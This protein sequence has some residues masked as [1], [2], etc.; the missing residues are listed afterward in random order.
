[1]SVGAIEVDDLD[2]LVA[3]IGILLGILEQAQP[4]DLYTLNTGWFTH[5]AYYLSQVPTK[6]AG[7]LLDVLGQLLDAAAGSAVGTPHQ[8][9]GRTWYPIAVPDSSGQAEASPFYLVAPTA[10]TSGSGTN[11]GDAPVLGVGFRHDFDAG[12]GA[13]VTAYGYLPL[14]SLA[15]SGVSFVLEQAGGGG[16]PPQ[17]GIELTGIEF[18]SG[19]VSF[20]GLQVAADISFSEA[21]AVTVVFLNLALPGR[22]PA[23]T[24]LQDLIVLGPAE[25]LASA[26]SLVFGQ[27]ARLLPDADRQAAENVFGDLLE[28]LG[29][30]PGLPS[31][32]WTALAAALVKDGKP[33]AGALVGGWLATLGGTPATMRQWLNALACLFNGTTTAVDGSDIAG[34]VPGAGTQADPFRVTV[35][36]GEGLELDLLVGLGQVNGVVHIYP[37]VRAAGAPL[38]LPDGLAAAATIGLSAQVADLQVSPTSLT[39]A[40]AQSLDA[41]VTLGATTAG[42]A[43]FGFE[44]TDVEPNGALSLGSVSGG[45]SYSGGTL[46]PSFALLDVSTPI[47]SWPVI[48]LANYGQSVAALEKAAGGV[49]QS[50]IETFLGAVGSEEPTGAAAAICAVLGVLAPAADA[51]NWPVSQLLFSD[52]DALVANPLTAVGAYWE[53]VIEA[54]DLPS[55][56]APVTVLLSSLATVLGA[57]DSSLSGSG[58]ALNPWLATLATVDDTVSVILSAWLEGSASAGYDLHLGLRFGVPFTLQGGQVALALDAG[59]IA[60]SLP[61]AG[62]GSY[63]ASWFELAGVSAALSGSALT[64]PAVGGVSLTA[65]AVVV[66]GGYGRQGLYG[67]V[68]ATG[69]QLTAGTVETPLGDIDVTVTEAGW[70]SGQLELLMGAVLQLAGLWLLEN[71][72]RPGVA[73]ATVLGLLPDIAAVYA[74]AGSANA[75]CPLPAGFTLPADWPAVTISDGTTFLG[76]P[77]QPFAAQLQALLGTHAR[78]Q[79]AIGLCAWALTGTVTI[80]QQA[81]TR[82]APMTVTLPGPLGLDVLVWSEGEANL[83]TRAGLGVSWTTTAT[84]ADT[85][86][87]ATTLRCDIATLPLAAPAPTPAGPVPQL[88]ASV[89]LAGLD[90]AP[91]SSDS[92]SGLTIG[93]ALV[94]VAWQRDGLTPLL[95]FDGVV[96]GQSASAAYTIADLLGRGAAGGSSNPSASTE[97]QVVA[98]LTGTVMQMLADDVPEIGIPDPPTDR[99]LAILGIL[100][101]VGLAAPS[102]GYYAIDPTS[103]LAFLADPAG[104]LA[105]GLAATL[106]D[107]DGAGRLGRAVGALAGATPPPLSADLAPIWA[108]L[109]SLGLATGT[110]GGPVPKPEAWTAVLQNPAGYLTGAAGAVF[111]DPAALIGELGT[112]VPAGAAQPVQLGGGVTLAVDKAT[113]VTLTVPAVKPGSWLE[114]GGSFILDLKAMSLTTG[115]TLAVPP[116]ALA[117]AASVSVNGSVESSW[118][119]DV[120]DATPS[121]VPAAFDPIPILGADAG[122]L[123]VALQVAVP[124]FAL[125]AVAGELIER[126]LLADSALARAAFTAV[127]LVDPADPARVRGLVR[128]ARAPLAWLQLALGVT[129]DGTLNLDVV[130]TRLAAIG[131]AAGGTGPGGV[132]LAASG[133]TGLTVGGLPYESSVSLT[134]SSAGGVACAVEVS[135]DVSPCTLTLSPSLG[136]LPASGLTLGGSVAGAVALSATTVTLDGGYAAG[137]WSLTL[138]AASGSPAKTTFT[139][140]LVPF[141]GVNAAFAASANLLL[142]YVVDEALTYYNATK[143][144]LPASVQTAVDG[145]V[146][147]A[148]TLGVTDGTSL[149]TLVQTIEK[150]PVQWLDANL[151]NFVGAAGAVLVTT[152]Q[153]PGVSVAGNLITYTRS[154]LPAG[155]PLTVSFGE[156]TDLTPNLLGAWLHAE[157]TFTPFVT[158]IDCGVGVQVP[159]PLSGDPVIDGSLQLVQCVDPTVLKP[160]APLLGSPAVVATVAGQ[161]VGGTSSFT[162]QGWPV[163]VVDVTDPHAGDA[164]VIALAPTPGLAYGDAPGTLLSTGYGTWLESFAYGFGYPILGGLVLSS[165]EVTTWLDATVGSSGVKVGA[166]LQALGLLAGSSGAW[167]PAD[168]R[169][170]FRTVRTGGGDYASFATAKLL[171]VLELLAGAPLITITVDGDS[172]SVGIAKT[173]D[174]DGGNV[175]GVELGLPEVTLATSAGGPQVVFQPGSWPAGENGTTNWIS[176]SNSDVTASQ[177]GIAI[178]LVHAPSTGSPTLSPGLIIVSAGLDL[179]GAPGKPLVDLPEFQLAGVETRVYVSMI[180]DLSNGG[181]LTTSFGAAAACTGLALSLAPSALAPSAGQSNPVAQ[182]LLSSGGGGSDSAPAKSAAPALTALAA[183]VEGG[184]LV[185]LLS[186]PANP[187]TFTDQTVWIPVQRALGPL[188]CQ[189]VGV[190]PPAQSG[191]QTLGIDFDGSVSLAGL[192][193]DLDDLSIGIPLTSPVDFDSYTLGLDGMSVALSGGPVTIAGGLVETADTP[194]GYEGMILVQAADLGLSAIGAYSVFDQ[195]PSFFVFGMLRAPLG[196]PPF[197]FVTGIAAGFGYNR[198]LAL[199]SITADNVDTFPLMEAMAGSNALKNPTDQTGLAATLDALGTAV[200]PSPGEYWLAAGVSFTSFDLLQS[201][202]LIAVSFGNDFRVDLL[203]VSQLVV[204]TAGGEI[205]P[206]VSAELDLDAS[207]RPSAGVL[208]VTATL[209]P[210]SHV[211]DPAVHLTGGFALDVWFSGDEEGQFVVTLGG[212]H[213][214]W[215]PPSF[216]PQEPRLGINWSWGNVQLTGDA[217]FALTPT[218]VMAGGDLDLTY[219]AGKLQAWLTVQADFLITWHPFAFEVGFEVSVGASYRVDA[220]LVHHTFTVELGA[221]VMMHGMPMGGTAHVHWYVI[222]FTISFGDDAVADTLKTWADFDNQL[223]PQPAPSSSAT[224]LVADTTPQATAIVLRAQAL[225]GVLSVPANED[226]PWLIT[227]GFTILVES[228][229]PV[230]EACLDKPTNPP[231][232]TAPASAPLGVPPLG[233]T[234]ASGTPCLASVLT[235]SFAPSGGGTTAE[236]I[237]CSPVVR[238]VPEA[239]WSPSPIDTTTPAANTIPKVV[240][241]FQ[242]SADI[243]QI[244]PRG[245]FA[246]SDLQPPEPGKSADWPSDSAATQ[247]TTTPNPV[248]TIMTTLSDSTTSAWRGEVLGALTPLNAAL[249]T[250]GTLPVLGAFADQILQDAPILVPLGTQY[251]AGDPDPVAA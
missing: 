16:L 175:Y 4:G 12:E 154:G 117:L 70:S 159:L 113:R 24:S 196:G 179:I 19:D 89:E 67:G 248:Q 53:R 206:I 9:L 171:A 97:M 23:D 127:G 180:E 125:G 22:A 130:G 164:V 88:A 111:G 239:L 152:F 234:S 244:G 197:F 219:S 131:A 153:L 182:S 122:S 124:I 199:D 208:S 231:F 80:P 134:S 35:A 91:L 76:D 3:Q 203:G 96:V 162:L 39:A 7:L 146:T 233:W 75:P 174:G 41:F 220:L 90:A 189:R 237:T 37:G 158:T 247:T 54:A 29:L 119:V 144:S 168:V 132:A 147:A 63:Y 98:Q 65:T 43:L 60:F 51:E 81:G 218:A 173:S 221:E 167:T 101:A 136:Y 100:D 102:G 32:D 184:H 45:L 224:Q 211:L 46:T 14:L 200:Y 235:I 120:V 56:A 48:D 55:G 109:E 64:T 215:V 123:P 250:G 209:A 87:A 108:V 217:Y 139:V 141:A 62:A 116:L 31:L 78:A 228:I 243:D 176:A 72:G 59:V 172:F 163:G 115:A 225:S 161:L 105:A 8:A 138:S 52:L 207:F 236:R 47:G 188:H 230:T 190:T 42:A 223:L 195:E 128:A 49:V 5:P 82:A 50:A 2:P 201:R 71:G 227:Q 30:T 126:S 183:W 240:V 202:A 194:P 165:D 181:K 112:L 140:P 241:G 191:A 69:V 135:A 107:A 13:T 86:T 73:A 58:S 27:L 114:L 143:S 85:L 40:A 185:L 6:N 150:G 170:E 212:Y 121:P 166:L 26:L 38:T 15:P 34:N 11:S 25:W 145:V 83:P 110:P 214:G 57:S 222:S 18:G 226:A 229:I 186:D 68:G 94:G 133:T 151:A 205:P 160:A 106:G 79:A 142:P 21:P 36:S 92:D 99:L 84:I 245:P 149:L 44:I 157:A 249:A 216:Y 20:D 148:G 74:L 137:D 33:G 17:L 129:T 156:R 242:L 1:M 104:F 95:E 232:Y 187:G 238:N 192:T 177:P 198:A 169:G 213:P 193:V 61:A 10:S 93:T 204:P 66:E 77:W 118:A 246:L 178:D 155:A 103:W 251:M 28:L 210:S